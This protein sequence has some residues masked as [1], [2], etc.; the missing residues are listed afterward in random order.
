MHRHALFL[1]LALLCTPAAFAQEPELAPPSALSPP[2][3]LSLPDEPAVTERS[4]VLGLSLGLVG[5]LAGG[6][7]LG[8][9]GF[10]AGIG[11]NQSG[12]VELGCLVMP[13]L[14]GG[15]GVILGIPLGTY[16][17]GRLTGGQGTL[18][19]TLLGSAVGWAAGILSGM[20]LYAGTGDSDTLVGPLL[21]MPVVGATLFYQLSH[22]DHAPRPKPSPR[23]SRIQVMPVAGYS[24]GGA[25]LGLVGSF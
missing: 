2:P 15:S 8:A 21:I 6:L 12:C 24:D 23:T 7:G 19:S 5:G 9:A 11:I 16:V 13:G 14:L 25:R 17:V 1:L 3:L 20:L 18:L 10:F 4:T 22:A